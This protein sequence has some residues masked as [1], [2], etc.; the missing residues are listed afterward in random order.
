M[1]E[2]ARFPERRIQ[3][4]KM[5]LFSK[6]QLGGLLSKFDEFKDIIAEHADKEECVKFLTEKTGL[7]KEQCE[8]AFDLIKKKLPKK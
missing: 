8:A 1:A 2:G 7:A 5:D 6:D 3:E 4:E